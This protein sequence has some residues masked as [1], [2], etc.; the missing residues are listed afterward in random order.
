MTIQRKRAEAMWGSHSLPAVISI[1]ISSVP[2]LQG[3]L[4]FVHEVV[5]MA[6]RDRMRWSQLAKYSMLWWTLH[7]RQL[8]QRAH[9]DVRNVKYRRV[10]GRAYIDDHRRSYIECYTSWNKSSQLASTFRQIDTTYCIQQK[11]ATQCIRNA[12]LWCACLMFILPRLL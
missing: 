12:I 4:P 8:L 9:A 1:S 10:V 6:L 7:K 2:R 5:K 3:P 11:K